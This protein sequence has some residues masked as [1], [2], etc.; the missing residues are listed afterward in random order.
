MLDRPITYH[1]PTQRPARYCVVIV[2]PR[3]A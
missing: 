3:P 1:N 2:G